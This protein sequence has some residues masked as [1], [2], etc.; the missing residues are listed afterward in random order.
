[1]T[2]STGEDGIEDSNSVTTRIVPAACIPRALNEL[3]LFES[4]DC[5]DRTPH[6]GDSG[7]SSSSSS[8]SDHRN[9]RTVERI[10]IDPPV[11][12]LRNAITPG[13]CFHI[14]SV[15]MSMETLMEDGKTVSDGGPDEP[16]PQPPNPEDTTKNRDPRKHSRVGWLGNDRP[17]IEAIARRA[18]R[19]FLNGTV[20]F[21][22]TRGIEPMQVVHYHREGGEYVNHHDGNGRIL[23]VLYYL[24]GVGATWFPL[25]GN[26][27]TT[28]AASGIY[29]QQQHNENIRD[30]LEARRASIGKSPDTSGVLVTCRNDGHDGTTNSGSRVVA[31]VNEGDAVAFYNYK[32]D[33]SMNWR[34]F[35]SGLP[36]TEE[37]LGVGMSDGTR[38][39]GGKWIANHFY[40]FVPS[41]IPETP[42]PKRPAPSANR[43]KSH[44]D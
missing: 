14:R 40:H 17:T 34:A 20:P 35:H 9:K 31:G 43:Q 27:T 23:T 15:A 21:H 33:G 5:D 42:P 25:A 8:S 18:H 38:N 37:D 22:A 24:N 16:S 12:V 13:E 7:S 4:L 39:A 44:R 19:V 10:S 6:E 28:T 29:P 32:V 11:F 2:V 30:L 1:M 26:A 36:V 41:H 3:K